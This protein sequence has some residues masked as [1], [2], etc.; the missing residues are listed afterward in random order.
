MFKAIV[1]GM[2]NDNLDIQD[3][4][5]TIYKESFAK[6]NNTKLLMVKMDNCK[7]ILVL[8]KG[9]LY[10]MLKGDDT[11]EYKICNLSHSNRLVLNEYFDYTN[12]I[13]AGKLIPTLGL[14]DRLG[15]ASPGHIE[16]I[17]NRGVIPVLAQQSIRELDLTGRTFDDV[18]DAAAFAV[19]QQ[20]YKDGFVADG[21]HL[22][23]EEDIKMSLDLGYTMITLDCSEKIDNTIS[24]LT[25]EEVID[26]YNQISEDIR[27][28]YENKYLSKTFA[29]EDT[30]ISFNKLSL[31]KDVLV[32]RDAIEFMK[33]IYE[34]YIKTLER[35]IDFEISIDETLTSTLPQSHFFIANEL[36]SYSIEINS[37]APKFCGEF[38][39]GI[40]YIGDLEQFEREF[41]VHTQIADYFGYKISIHSGS[42]KFSVYPFIGKYTKGRFHVKTAGTNWL[43][44]I[45]VVAM[46]NPILYRKMHQYALDHFAEAKAYYHVTTDISLIRPLSEV[47]DGRLIDYMDEDNARQ[48]LHICY[49]ILLQAKD[50]S[51]KLLFKEEF[52]KTLNNHEEE[53]KAR[54]ISHIG[55]HL[56]LLGK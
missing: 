3:Q 4:N 41:K 42:D 26:K 27:K 43:E 22:K 56:T 52:Y 17:R 55:K 47:E 44:A 38:Q 30:S 40:D 54:L 19:F 1:N 12:P 15:I 16:A 21:D 45:K 53:Y 23:R 18:L 37:M 50:E 9:I 34:N 39:K 28:Y 6:Y 5:I 46:V 8:G 25:E 24:S 2:K 51:G 13:A 35:N 49:G 11:K 29:I 7:Y 48:L 14:G 20:G 31:M 33:S 10:D 36:D 32:Y